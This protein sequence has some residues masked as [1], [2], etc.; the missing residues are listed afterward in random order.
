MKLTQHLYIT[1]P[2]R[3]LRGQYN[4]CFALAEN[5]NMGDIWTYCGEVE[6]NFEVDSSKLA[7]QVKDE[8]KRV[9]GVHL[10]KINIMQA[11]LDE[12]RAPK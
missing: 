8:I 3:F 7:E 6:L 5:A 11:H 10:K 12:L 2:E 4:T 9:E 1:S